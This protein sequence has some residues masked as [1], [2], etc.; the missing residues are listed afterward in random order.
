MAI[1]SR[2][3]QASIV[4][5]LLFFVVSSPLSYRIVDSLI[6]GIVNYTYIGPVLS[7]IFK[8]A[9]AGCPT[10]YGLILH[11]AVFGLLTYTLMHYNN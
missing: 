5:A 1:L 10:N 9:Q 6:S 7:P 8:V 11:S 3:A 4:A 2:K